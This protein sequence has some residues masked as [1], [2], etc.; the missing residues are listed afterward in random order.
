MLERY[1]VAGGVLM[2][3]MKLPP[4]ISQ[5]LT[6]AI[7]FHAKKRNVRAINKLDNI[8]W[9]FPVQGVFLGTICLFYVL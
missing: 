6:C 8:K 1:N 2:E 5:H 7:P 3:C 4:L 9:S